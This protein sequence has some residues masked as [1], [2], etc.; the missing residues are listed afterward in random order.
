MTGSSSGC[1]ELQLQGGRARSKDDP[2]TRKRTSSGSPVK[3]LGPE[4][5][6]AASSSTAPHGVACD[7]EAMGRILAHLESASFSSEKDAM[8]RTVCQNFVFTTEQVARILG[9]QSM[10]SDKL[11]SL[12]IFA[13]SVS[14]PTETE[15][16][17]EIFSFTDDKEAAIAKLSGFTPAKSGKLAVFPIEADGHRSDADIERFIEAL[18]S[19]SFSDGKVAVAEAECTEHPTPPFSSSQVVAILKEFSF[20][21]DAAR[22]LEAFVG[23]AIV[24][25]MSCAELVEVLEVFSM[26]SDRIEI[27]PTLKKFI[28]DPQNKLDIVCSFTFSSD[29]EQAEEILRD[30]VVKLEPPVPPAAKIQETLRRIGRCP[31]G[32][33]WRQVSNGWRCAAGGHFVSTEALTA[34]M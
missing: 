30:V 6:M 19:E 22:V 32:Y 15:P 9:T 21:S 10:D 7:E 18:R 16:V 14:N 1:A 31:A 25:P 33:A 29:K 34:A 4:R 24:Y 13:S 27:L 28:K 3:K 11:E 5:P 8:Y 26:S 2:S 12:D 23:P 17:G 20:T